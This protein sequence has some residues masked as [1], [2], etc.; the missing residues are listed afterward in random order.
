MPT[1]LD[2]Q[3]AGVWQGAA[4]DALPVFT[5]PSGQNSRGDGYRSGHGSARGDEGGHTEGA[6]NGFDLP[7]ETIP[8]V[9]V[10]HGPNGAPVPP[11][12][13][14]S[15]ELI[16]HKSVNCSGDAPATGGNI[17]SQTTRSSTPRSLVSSRRGLEVTPRLKVTPRSQSVPFASPQRAPLGQGR[18]S[19]AGPSGISSKSFRPPTHR[20]IEARDS[21]PNKQ[22]LR[23]LCELCSCRKHTCP[24]HRGNRPFQGTTTHKDNYIPH[25]HEQ[26]QQAAQFPMR[27]Q[28]ELRTQ[29]LGTFIS[30]IMCLLIAATLHHLP[31]KHTSD[32][33]R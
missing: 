21:S 6:G 32:R 27:R 31:G 14:S 22:S 28:S 3:P 12:R 19:P 33:R 10:A 13:L 20:D 17:G 26:R 25:T 30:L 4:C 23:C 24:A 2:Q 18:M 5:P 1:R 9:T 29:N 7:C 16:S 11:L 15:Q 8:P